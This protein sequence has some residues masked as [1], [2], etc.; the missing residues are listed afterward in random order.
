[1]NHVTG[2]ENVLDFP[3]REIENKERSICV[4]GFF[5][6][7][8][9]LADKLCSTRLSDQEHRVL[10]AVMRRTIGYHKL[11]DW[12]S[13][14]QLHEMTDIKK[15]NLSKTIKTLLERRILVREGRKLGINPTVSEW[16]NKARTLS[17]QIT[18]VMPIDNDCYANRQ[19]DHEQKVMPMDNAVI[20]TDN[21]CYA[22]RQ[23][24]KNTILQNTN[25][26]KR[27]KKKTLKPPDQKSSPPPVDFSVFEGITSEQISELKRIRKANKGGPISQRVA[28]QLAKEFIR[29]RQYGFTLDDCLTEWETRSW[30]SFKAAWVAPKSKS[31]PDFHN[32]DTSWAKDLGW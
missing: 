8:N 28:N 10:F 15:P 24:Q 7:P 25:I 1:M 29:A 12:V 17:K 20:Q 21:N 16:V 2:K 5:S 14:E 13:L 3:E 32:G 30:K 27:N 26:K 4:S 23:P 31:Y 11:V 18:K 6:I 19:P 9:E 22:D